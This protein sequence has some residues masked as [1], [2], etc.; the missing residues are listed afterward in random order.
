MSEVFNAEKVYKKIK[1]TQSKYE[2]KIHCPMILHTMYNNGTVS[3]FCIA[4]T[5]S[6]STFY[7]WVSK[8]SLFQEC[9][10]IGYMYARENWEECGRIF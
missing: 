5:I 4:A 9:Y 2:E 10:R 8:H 3:S 7:Q 1:S 6:D